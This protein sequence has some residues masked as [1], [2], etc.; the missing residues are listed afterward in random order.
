LHLSTRVAEVQR[1]GHAWDIAGEPYDAV[2][3]ATTAREAARLTERAAPSWAALAA[4]LRYEPIV[5]VYAT[6]SGTRLPQ[7]MLAL[8]ADEQGQPAQFVFDHAHLG[9]PAGLLAFVISGAGPWL[10]RGIE[11][12]LEATLKQGRSLLA[13]H[14]KAPLQ[15]IRVLTE[16]RATFQCAPALHRPPSTVM[17]GLYAAGDYVDGPYPATLEG[18]VRSAIFAIRTLQERLGGTTG[19]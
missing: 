9:G 16:K 12:T 7:P 19:P 2:V 11:L 1:K 15:P 13:Q 8:N 10:E 3:L 6:S 17:P 18:A 4:A 5:T 14:L